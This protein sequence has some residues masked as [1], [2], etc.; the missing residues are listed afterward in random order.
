VLLN[1]ANLRLTLVTILSSFMGAALAS[2]F[3]NVPLHEVL[4]IGSGFGWY[5]GLTLNGTKT[6]VKQCFPPPTSLL[7]D[8]DAL[9]SPVLPAFLQQ[10]LP[11]YA[12]E[13]LNALTFCFGNSRHDPVLD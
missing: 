5:R 9:S 11:L 6:H 3:I 1:K 4:A 10:P 7:M 12:A 13:I 8:A 2:L